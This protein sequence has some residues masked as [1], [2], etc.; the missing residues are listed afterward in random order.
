MLRSDLLDDHA[1]D[2]VEK[3]TKAAAERLFPHHRLVRAWPLGQKLQLLQTI[4]LSVSANVM[5]LLSSM[6]CVSES[7]TKRLDQL[8]KKIAR[9]ALRLPGS[10][11]YAYVVA[12]AGLGDVTGM[13]TQ[14]R[15]RLQLSLELHPLR[16]LA[17]PPIACQMLE[18]AKAEAACFSGHSLLLAPWPLITNRIAGKAVEKCTTEGWNRPDKR[19]EAPPYAS[20]VGRVSERER[21]IGKSLSG[22]DYACHN[23]AQRPPSSAKGQLAALHWSARLC[24]TDLGGVPKLTPLSARGP[25]GNGSIVAA[26]RLLSDATHIIT[27]ARQGNKAMH[28]F[29]FANSEQS[30]VPNAARQSETARSAR[31]SPDLGTVRLRGS[32]CHLCDKGDDGPGFDLWHVLFECPATC[33][34]ADVVA[35]RQSCV[36]FLPR[37]CEAVEDAVRWNG[38]SMSN[39]ENAGVSHK[40]IVD[41]VTRVREAVPVYDWECVPGRWLIYTLLLALPFSERVVCPDADSPMW[42]CAPKRRVKGVQRVRDLTGMPIVGPALPDDQ[43][44]LPKLVGAMF[45]RTVLAHDALRPVPDA[46]CRHALIGLFRVGR[47]VR[48]LRAVAERARAAARVAAAMGGDSDE[49]STTS[50]VSTTDSDAGSG[51]TPDSDSEP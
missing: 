29:P 32:S 43:Y 26:S 8:W 23:F 7:K 30:G 38:M 9:S 39:T 34:H 46:G 47:V 18:I 11:R 36:D 3:K 13:I 14:H 31:K 19:C 28:R 33:A 15:L 49:R 45:D 4:V 10:A 20:L 41:A 44:L 27:M 40:D 50:F 2:R 35:V 51:S 24:P 37:L 48:P 22:L 5:P 21:W 6:R 1:Y 17:A 16:D 42:L 12:E 25:H